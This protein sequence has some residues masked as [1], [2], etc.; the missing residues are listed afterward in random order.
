MEAA[1]QALILHVQRKFMAPPPC[2]NGWAM[3]VQEGAIQF[4]AM[5]KDEAY[6][7][8]ALDYDVHIVYSLELPPLEADGGPL[9]EAHFDNEA[10][11]R[12]VT[13]PGTA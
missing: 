6:C 4:D 10:L 7:A 11:G 5:L 8:A 2:L 9:Q 3:N 13:A 1:L 12:T